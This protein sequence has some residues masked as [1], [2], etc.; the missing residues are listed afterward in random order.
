MVKANKQFLLGAIAGLCNCII[1]RL[2]LRTPRAC[3]CVHMY[4]CESTTLPG[5]LLVE[6][7]S[8]GETL[9]QQR[10][11]PFY[12]LL[13]QLAGFFSSRGTQG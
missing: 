8:S 9:S 11:A 6:A 7:H 3:V 5:R 13:L 10:T 12:C 2:D 4:V 1:E